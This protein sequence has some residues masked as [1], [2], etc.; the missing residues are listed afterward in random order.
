MIPSHT[1]PQRQCCC[2]ARSRH[3]VSL[4]SQLQL[5]D[6]ISQISFPKNIDENIIIHGIKLP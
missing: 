1:E 3:E 2:S 5:Q 6:F 4:E